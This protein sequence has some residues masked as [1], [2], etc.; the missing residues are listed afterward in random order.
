[1]RKK[2]FNGV[3]YDRLDQNE[4][5]KF[6]F[7]HSSDL[8]W[9]LDE[10][11]KTKYISTSVADF[12]GYSTE[13]YLQLSLEKKISSNSIKIL[14]QLYEY[15]SENKYFNNI[16]IDYINKNGLIVNTIVNGKV[17]K[18]EFGRF[19][20]IYGIS[21]NISNELRLQNE[22]NLEKYKNNEAEKFKNSIIGTL[23]HEFRTPLS[24][25]IGFA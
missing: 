20:G 12:L 14:D 21:K 4:F 5:M 9:I 8:F 13:E 18:D 3:I 24:G 23:G 15:P 2:D 10:N 25:I 17:V 16:R 19:K 6:V 1:M 22:L 7:D 11:K